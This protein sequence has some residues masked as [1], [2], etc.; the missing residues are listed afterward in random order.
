MRIAFFGDSLTEGIP[1]VSVLRKLGMMLP[2]HELENFGK[3]GD[4]VI[5][6]YRRIAQDPHQGAADTAVLW[7]GVNDILAKI[8]F[9]HSILK[10]W[11]RQPRAKNLTEF[12]DYYKRTVELLLENAGR[13]LAV[14]PLLIGEDLSNPWNSELDDLGG[15]IASVAASFGTVGFIDLRAV[16]AHRLVASQPSNYIPNRVTTIACDTLFLRTP[17]AVD[18]AASRR[19]LQLTLDGIHLNSTGATAVAEALRQALRALP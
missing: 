17:R 5:S 14:S 6:L 16:I 1:G 13:V 18:S 7:I 10:R 9:G 19:G 8:S 4:T 2:E 11:M 15:I 3:R 12:R